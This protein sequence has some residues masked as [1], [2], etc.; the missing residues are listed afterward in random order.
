MSRFYASIKGNRGKATRTG[1][2]NSGMTGHVRGWDVGVRAYMSVGTNGEDVV[3]IYL[4]AGSR[5][6]QADIK[7]GEFTSE[8]LTTKRAVT[9]K[10]KW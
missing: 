8:N 5:G 7:L 10:R 3:S 6:L 2:P 4:T 9:L 1:T